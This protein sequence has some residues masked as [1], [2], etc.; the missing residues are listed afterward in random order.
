[1][2]FRRNPSGLIPLNIMDSTVAA[3]EDI[4]V[5]GIQHSQDLNWDTHLPA[6]EV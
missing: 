5:P 1:M 4:Q 6:E 3:V 2:D